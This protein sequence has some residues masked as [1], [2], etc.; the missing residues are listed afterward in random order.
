[1][2]KISLRSFFFTQF[3]KTHFTVFFTSLTRP[4]NTF[5]LVLYLLDTI[6]LHYNLI[7]PFKTS[8]P[9]YLEAALSRQVSVLAQSRESYNRTD[10]GSDNNFDGLSEEPSVRQ[11][12]TVSWGRCF[13]ACNFF[14]DISRKWCRPDMVT[15]PSS[16]NVCQVLL[17]SSFRQM[18]FYLR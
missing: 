11:S 12:N 5:L 17:Q 9:I 8:H 1:M 16:N 18:R 3:H 6:Y 15:L 2:L 13:W 4:Y 10:S 7:P 14:F